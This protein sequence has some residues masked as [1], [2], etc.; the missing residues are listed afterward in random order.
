MWTNVPIIIIYC[1]VA[2]DI[3]SNKRKEENKEEEEQK[4]NTKDF[5]S[6]ITTFVHL[7]DFV[8]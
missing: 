7:T 4:K 3:E 5:K 1:F 2:R 6:M 8:C